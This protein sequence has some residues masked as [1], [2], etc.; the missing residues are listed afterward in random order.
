MT[1]LE[2]NVNTIKLYMHR[3]LDPEKRELIAEFVFSDHAEAAA[4]AL[5]KLY[6]YPVTIENIQPNGDFSKRYEW[7]TTTIMAVKRIET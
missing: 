2:G 1:A 3:H 6:K 5:V 7:G 4:Q